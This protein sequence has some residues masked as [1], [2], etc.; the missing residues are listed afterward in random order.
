MINV[1]F[2]LLDHV[3][4]NRINTYKEGL[5]FNEANSN[6]PLFYLNQYPFYVLINLVYIIF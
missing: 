5:K 6:Y 2:L 4:G 1:L 3:R